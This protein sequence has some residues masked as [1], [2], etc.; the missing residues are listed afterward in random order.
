MSLWAVG[1]RPQRL[2]Q[3]HDGVLPRNELN[4]ERRLAHVLSRSLQLHHEVK[5]RVAGLLPALTEP[6]YAHQLWLL[7]P[8]LSFQ[9][10]HDCA[11]AHH[12]LMCLLHLIVLL[13]QLEWC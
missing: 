8:Q 12:D 5:A 4:E 2:S 11:N 3:L 7:Q 9:Q 13:Q 1:G 6:A 10:L